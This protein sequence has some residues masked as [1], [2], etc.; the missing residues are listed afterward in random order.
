MTRSSRRTAF[1]FWHDASI[2]RKLPIAFS[3]LLTGLVGLYMFAA[4]RGVEQSAAETVALRLDRVSTELAQLVTTSSQT[5]YA[6]VQR[7]GSAPPI[8]SA[9]R[10]D[11][12]MKPETALSRLRIGND[13][14]A[15]LLLDHK[16]Q[17]IAHVGPPVPPLAQQEL[18]RI[19]NHATELRDATAV[20]RF[21]V[22][23]NRG[24]WWQ[25]TALREDERVVGYFAQL[26]RYTG[27]NMSA[28]LEELIG[29]ATV[30]FG[31]RDDFKTPWFQLD[32]EMVPAPTQTHAQEG[33]HRHERAN[34]VSI[35]ST[36]PIPNTPWM[37]IA[38]TSEQETAARAQTFLRRTAPIALAVVLLGIVLS[39]LV[40]RRFSKPIRELADA[41]DAVGAG[42]YEQ[43]VTLERGD[44]L[45][46][47]AQAFN[48]MAGEVERS[49]AHSDS[50]R[51]DAETANRAK[52]EFLANMSHEIR[53]PI[54]AMIGYADLLD[55]GVHGQIN[56]EQRQQLERIRLSGA[57][58]VRLVDDLLDYARIE[59]GRIS[60]R[61]EAALARGAVMTAV[62]VVEPQAK[63]KSVTVTADCAPDLQYHGD[64][65]RVGQILVNLLSNA[66]KFSPDGSRVTV[67]C[68]LGKR[69]GRQVVEFDVEDNGPGI[70][71]ARMDSIFEA[72]VQA[73][74]GYTRPHGGAG[75]GLT[76]SK[77]LAEA[78]H[79]EILVESKLGAGSTFTLVM[80]A[81]APARTPAS[82]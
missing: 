65:D 41:A 19:L 8:R 66:V 34:A 27:S 10:G 22:E 25:V 6:L 1:S 71:P 80:P 15:I 21:F 13:T 39:W 79:G 18:S 26:R 40:S 36:K 3:V 50:S 24:T 20:G 52:S 4:Y 46:T 31:N 68:G 73:H 32:G 17:V 59:T 75:L 57:H 81:V 16:Q 38:E 28:S 53:T 33:G 78:M 76:I 54:N 48:K 11:L 70:E 47:L 63:A 14:S 2:E 72:F 12:T 51:A 45:G 7:I 44:E 60:I 35:A 5:R 23:A 56:D 55:L 61:D 30:M 64:A 42:H 37:V 9:L 67:R 77:R 82:V 74:S 43:R 58:L 69:N 49:I 62:T 29:D